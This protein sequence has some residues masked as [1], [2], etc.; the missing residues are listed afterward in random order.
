MKPFTARTA[1]RDQGFTLI[2]LMIVVAIVGILA[3]IAYP[4]YQSHV[5]KTRRVAAAGCLM[6]LSQWMERSYT[7]CLAYNVTGVGCATAM[8]S[9]VLPNLSCRNDLG[10]AYTFEFSAAPTAAAY[11]LRA[12][13]GGPQ[14]N[15]TGCANLT[16]TH[17]GQ[18]GVSGTTPVNAC[19]Q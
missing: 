4:S 7:T 3:A 9:A 16:I 19:W 5:L 1:R 6:E 17:V 18:K 12:V 2:E 11:A 10:A 13:P 14:A 8:S 15:D